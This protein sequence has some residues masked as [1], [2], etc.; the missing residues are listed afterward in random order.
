M[1][2]APVL[3][4]VVTH[5]VVYLCLN[6]LVRIQT[7]Y[8]Y[9]FVHYY[10]FYLILE[11]ITLIEIMSDCSVCK[12]VTGQPRHKITCQDCKKMCHAACVN[13]SKDDIDYIVT[14]KQIWRCPPCSKVKRQSMNSD[15]VSSSK[16]LDRVLSDVL[17][18]LNEAS[19]DRK[20]IEAE[21]NKSFDFVNEQIVEQNKVIKDQNEK[22]SEFLQL[23]D[24]LKTENRMLV[25]KVNELEQRLEENEQYLRSNTVEIQGVPENKS[26]DVYEVVQKVGV[27]LDVNISREAIDVCH[28][29]GKKRDSDRP[30]GIIVKFVRREDKLK[31]LEKRR[32]KRNLNSL[33][34][35]YSQTPAIPVYVNESLS[36]AKRKLLAAA[37]LAKSDKNYKFLGVR[38]G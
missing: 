6:D 10:C 11:Y 35:G 27:A 17:T 5:R 15:E 21:I 12:K 4:S 29:L 28:R 31:L 22:M 34:V 7:N 37:R 13:L 25:R 32:V 20:R 24:S 1:A 9:I 14:E 30:A 26:E 18:K 23:I 19:D 36:P 8:S 33:D 3:V 2:G 38:N 16:N